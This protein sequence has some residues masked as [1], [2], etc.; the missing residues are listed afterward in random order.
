[1]FMTKKSNCKQ[2]TDSGSENQ[3]EQ[4]NHGDQGYDCEVKR[5]SFPF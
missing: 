5:V 2:K 3:T 1:M 4:N